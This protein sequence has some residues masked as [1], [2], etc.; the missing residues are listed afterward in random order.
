[1]KKSGFQ[2]VSALA[3]LSLAGCGGGGGGSGGP[4]SPPPVDPGSFTLSAT[5]AAFTSYQGRNPPPARSLQLQIQ[6]TA[7]VAA[8]GAAY[9][10]PNQPASWLVVN[11]TGADAQYTLELSVNPAN[12]APGSYR[13]VITVGTAT[14]AGTILKTRNVTIDY[15]HNAV[16]IVGPASAL[17]AETVL[18]HHDITRTF[19][20]A[21][22]APAGVNWTASSN[23]PWL[24]VPSTVF[25]GPT[26][27]TVTVDATGIPP[28]ALDGQLTWTSQADPENY[29]RTS[30]ALVVVLPELSVT[31]PAPVLGGADGTESP[32]GALN[33]S[34]GTGTNVHPLAVN[35][36]TSDG[37]PWL[38]V[39]ASAPSVG[40]AGLT[41]DLRAQKPEVVPGAYSATVTITATVE[42]VAISQTRNVQFNW[43]THSLVASTLGVGF[44]QFPGRSLLQRRVRIAS[45][46]GDDDAHWNASSD[47]PW[48]T[49]TPA[50]LTGG[51][52]QLTANPAGLA[53]GQL[54]RANVTVS[55]PDDYIANQQVIRVALWIGTS[56]PVD[57]W[58]A[59]TG[60]Q[61]ALSPV[62]PRAFI[63]ESNGDISV[64]DVY[65]G[66]WSAPSRP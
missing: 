46:Y 59:T 29:T 57:S 54:H 39:D 20:A 51:E 47:T 15:T 19:S 38:D 48:L 44:S 25:T 24:Q 43:E 40:D 12:L 8:V 13:A 50:G 37:A 27:V 53:V 35:V 36:V 23:Q 61:I 52:V 32:E 49:V 30:A 41:L 11:L 22:N 26:T 16:T 66:A 4:P 5:S 65:T 14:S 60:Y 2:L 3:A 18:G 10:A 31:D 17:N 34:L 62:D 55:S 63:G 6:N 9:V 42:G 1:M 21:V 45:S 33:V 7:S 28:G 56:D 58:V 64:Y